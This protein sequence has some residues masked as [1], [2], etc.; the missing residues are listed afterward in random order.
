[1]VPSWQKLC[2]P[3]FLLIHLTVAFTFGIGLASQL[4]EGQTRLSW[5][6]TTACAA[7]TLIASLRNNRW[8]HGL[9]LI[10]FLATGLLHGQLHLQ[11]NLPASH[12]S[13][14]ITPDQEQTCLATLMEPPRIG[15]ER[16]QLLVATKEL[17]L[18]DQPSKA[19]EMAVLPVTGLVRVTMRGPPPAPL[20]PGDSLLI[21]GRFNPPRGFHNPASFNLP[22][23]LAREEIF[24]TAWVTSPQHI[25]ALGQKT[26]GDPGHLLLAQRLRGRIITFINQTLP[27]PTAGLY[28]ALLTGDR[29]GLAPETREAFQRLGIA[30]LLAISGLHMAL[31]AAGCHLLFS[32]LVS[33]SEFLLLH[34]PVKKIVAAISLVP[35]LFYCLVSGLQP[36]AVRAFI[37]ISLFLLAIIINGQ[38]H[39]PTNISLAALIILLFNPAEL[40]SASFQLSFAAVIGLALILPRLIAPLPAASNPWQ[41]T[42][43]WLITGLAVA[44]AAS[45]ATLP[46]VLF[47]FQRTSLVGVAA[48]LVFE[49]IFCIWS[50]TW[51]LLA[52][53]FIFIFPQLA[54][55]LLHLG[56]GGLSLSHSLA[57][58]WGD[59][60]SISLWLPPPA[61]LLIAI[62]FGGLF[63]LCLSRRRPVQLV[64]L[65]ACLLL[66]IPWPVSRPHD[67]I[68]I[69]DVGKGNCA[70][71][72]LKSGETILVDGGGPHSPTFDVGRRVIAP[73][74]RQQR[75]KELDLIIVSHGD[76]DHYS[77]IPFLL[78]NFPC[79]ELWLAAPLDPDPGLQRLVAAARQQQV[80]IS[81]PLPGA[82]F[83]ARASGKIKLLSRLHLQPELNDNE[84]SLVI[85]FRSGPHSFLLPGDIG[86]TGERALIDDLG[87]HTVLVAPHHGSSSSSSP[88]FIAAANPDY[89]IFSS[90]A[91]HHNRFPAPE[92]T[93]R[94]Q[95]QGA[96]ML[97]TGKLGA[98]RFTVRDEQLRPLLF[99]QQ[100]QH[101][102]P[103]P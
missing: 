97:H 45:V 73:Y 7:A 103:L 14:F 80:A 55:L 63:L 2:H 48:T 42:R 60:P 24:L 101:F 86:Q 9:L 52:V 78:K 20:T 91:F 21:H 34:L 31:L 39:T 36:P 40:S 62:Y 102:I 38:W 19:Q 88:P 3:S 5:L 54:S 15:R 94:Y 18:P 83:P 59:T 92:V 22:A 100:Q 50:L 16:S 10:T 71:I 87:H 57:L 75:I 35:L 61:P 89:T 32:W 25:V 26:A 53:P 72:E 6:L 30:H 98:I 47:Y 68:T 76:S 95:E 37:M 79:G 70:V 4:P 66:F 84:Q 11:P 8:R 33:R 27:P 81:Q 49:P 1:M 46:L 99:H 69:L 85:S 44:V 64:G 82:T 93:A 41:R 96:R 77:G 65:A 56:A 13:N 12:L 28:R 29:S 17:L 74:L 43:G 23:H 58:A 51:G 90:S 67:Q